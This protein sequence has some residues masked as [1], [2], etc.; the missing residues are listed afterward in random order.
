MHRSS[1]KPKGSDGTFDLTLFR[2]GTESS[3]MTGPEEIKKLREYA[4]LA[5][6]NPEI[7][8]KLADWIAGRNFTIEKTRKGL[9]AIANST[10]TKK[11]VLSWFRDILNET[12]KQ[13]QN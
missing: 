9:M 13:I 12:E 10:G 4:D 11:S 2:S 1:E 3:G 8:R 5:E 6:H 7:E